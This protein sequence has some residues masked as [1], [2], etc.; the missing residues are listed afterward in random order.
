MNALRHE[1][2]NMK[3]LEFSRKEIIFMLSLLFSDKNRIRTSSKSRA[4]LLRLIMI[5]VGKA[6]GIS[7]TIFS[8]SPDSCDFE[9]H[10]SRKPGGTLSLARM[11]FWGSGVRRRGLNWGLNS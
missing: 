10:R 8:G 11:C 6:S 3:T 7:I 9:S 2:V 4:L 1:K 5:L